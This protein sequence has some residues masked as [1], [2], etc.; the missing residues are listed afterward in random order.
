MPVL[1][2]LVAELPYRPPFLEGAAYWSL[3][4]KRHCSE[5]WVGDH[6]LVVRKYPDITPL[7]PL[8][9]PPGIKLPP[10]PL[11]FHE[12]IDYPCDEALL[13][14]LSDQPLLLRAYE[15][16]ADELRERFPCHSGIKLGGYPLL[17]QQTAF[18]MCLGPDFAIQI[19]ISSYFH[20][21]D[22]G[23]GYVN[24]DLTYACWETL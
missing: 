17:I 3:F 12:V 21:Q 18:L 10:L 14:I 2:I 19:D 22:A 23:I 9:V 4:T 20:Y 1:S 6:T 13:E 8:P 5:S 7:R 16:R 24:K 15:S 11:R